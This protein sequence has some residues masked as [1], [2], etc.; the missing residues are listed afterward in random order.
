MPR[1]SPRRRGPS[2]VEKHHDLA[3]RMSSPND[4]QIIRPKRPLTPALGL[5]RCF[6]PA[7]VTSGSYLTHSH[8]H[9]VANSRNMVSSTLQ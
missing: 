7:T 9:T 6:E 2:K 5:S 8:R 4:N 3:G 1:N